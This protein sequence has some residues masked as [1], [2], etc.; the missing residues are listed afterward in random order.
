MAN[1]TLSDEIVGTIGTPHD[2]Y[3]Y[4]HK[5]KDFI[6]QLKKEFCYDWVNN[7]ED[8]NYIEKCS[9]CKKINKLAGD[10]L[11]SKGDVQC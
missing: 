6:K 3:I 11:V 4:T 5:V 2:G 10:A 7:I 1:K 9:S 8:C